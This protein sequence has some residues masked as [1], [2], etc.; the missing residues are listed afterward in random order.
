M[1]QESQSRASALRSPEGLGL[2][3][4]DLVS[5]IGASPSLVECTVELPK[6][7]SLARTGRPAV[8]VY[9]QPHALV[10]CLRAT[11]AWFGMEGSS[12]SASTTQ[13]MASCGVDAGEG[14]CAEWA[15][16]TGVRGY[17]GIVGG[18]SGSRRSWHGD[19]VVQCTMRQ[20]TAANK[21][22]QEVEPQAREKWVRCVFSDADPCVA[23]PTQPKTLLSLARLWWC[24]PDE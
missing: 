6:R 11:T 10:T 23:L 14:R 18:E 13:C 19:Y 7:A 1:E 15:L 9:F 24:F 2:W 4:D 20:S 5:S 16:S 22:G 12:F 8:T 17:L 3:R 21:G